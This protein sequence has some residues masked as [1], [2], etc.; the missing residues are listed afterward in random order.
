[1]SM[2]SDLTP[3]QRSKPPGK[4]DRD[5][6]EALRARFIAD[7]QQTDLSAVRPVI[8]RSWKRSAMCNVSTARGMMEVTAEPQIDEQFLRC[9]DPVIAELERLCVDAHG[10]VSLADPTGT[11]SLFRGEPAMVRWAE[12]T[13]PT[14]GGAMSEELVG[15]N[16]DGT[17][18][19]EGAAVQ[20]WGG[21]HYNEALQDSYCTS[22]PI[23]DPLRRSIRG[24]LS[25]TLPEQLVVDLD[26]RT[27]LMIVQSAGAEIARALRDRLAPREQALLTEYLREVRKRGSEAVVA[28]DEHTTIMN[29]GAM[30]LLDQSDHAVLAAYAREAGAHA[31]TAEHE[32]FC[33]AGRI[34]QLQ[35]RPVA[36]GDRTSGSVMRLRQIRTPPRLVAMPALPARRPFDEMIGESPALR[37]ALDAADAAFVQRLPAFIFGEP[38]TGKT[39]LGRLLAE[40]M[41]ADASVAEIEWQDSRTGDAVAA[42]LRK[43]AAVL[44]G[45]A[46]RMDEDDCARLAE[47][48]EGMEGPRLVFTGT[49]F[50]DAI[51]PLVTML[52][53]VEVRM[54]PLRMRREDIAPLAAYFL[55]GLDRPRAAAPRLMEQLA[56]AEWP[57]NVAQLREA[58]ESAALQA[59]GRDVRSEDL[60]AIHRRALAPSHLSR[61]QK[62]ELQQIREALDEAGGNRLRAAEILRIGR[63][64]LYRRLDYYT[65]RGFDLT[66]DS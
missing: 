29:R 48:F 13:F 59:P 34:L 53:G 37:R 45:R 40:R 32:I 6:L 52:R 64:T 9:A 38:G 4:S 26:P 10:C 3:W 24:V 25:L 57:G 49:H 63:S 2:N 16:S 50:T 44:L 19:E 47:A 1:M 58:V 51:L 66:P 17:A 20:V 7:P 36:E 46:E 12:K 60:T 61:L 65:S 23:I 22:V 31:R 8:A 28:M 21:E 15:T 39:R 11:I 42:S 54:P 43:G 35:V 5:M 18:I 30:Q 14:V 55:A 62:A 33:A 56:A 41:S 27:I